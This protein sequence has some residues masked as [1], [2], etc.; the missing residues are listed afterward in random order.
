MVTH[1]VRT[2]I[3]LLPA[4]LTL[5]LHPARAAVPDYKL[6]DVATEDVITPVR[7]TVVN[8]EATEALK[9]RVS[10]Q[11]PFVVRHTPQTAAEAE[12]A[13]RQSVAAAR[14]T[15]LTALR[16]ALVGRT[17]T[18]AD[19]NTPAYASAIKLAAR[20][21]PKD[22]PFAK[23]A[24]LWVLGV[25]DTALVENLIQPLRDVM[26][27]PIVAS[28]TDSPWPANQPVWLVSVKGADGT[29]TIREL[30]NAGTTVSSGKLISVSRARRVVETSFPEGQEQMGRFAA[31]FVRP[32]ASADPKLTEVLRARRMDGVT[33]SDTYEPAQIIVRKGQIVDRRVLAALTMLREKSMIGTL[34][35]RLEQQQSVAAEIT[36]QTTWIAGGLGAVFLALLLVFWRLRRRLVTALVPVSANPE[37]PGAEQKALPGGAVTEAQWRNRALVAERKAERAHAAIRTGALGWMR[38]RIFQTLFRQRAELLSVQQRAEAEMRELERRLEK[39]HAPLQER[40]HA[41][42]R[43]IVELERELAARGEEDRELIGARIQMAR[44]QL[45]VERGRGGYAV[46]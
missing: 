12:A 34:Q 10:L 45:S 35:N 6:G 16:H 19:L 26:S 5:S 8:P 39:L 37:L 46:D 31:S 40:I 14:T 30:E 43:R 41:Y 24:P 28:K 17:P 9:R 21:S 33:V 44:Q 42:E 13:L 20:E 1:R 18:M 36:R 4:V 3:V 23:L 11:V 29:P 15:F 38:E 32:N 22:L 2:A 25:S 27:Q 7:L